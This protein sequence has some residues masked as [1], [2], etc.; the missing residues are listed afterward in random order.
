MSKYRIEKFY[1]FPISEDQLNRMS[2]MGWEL[3]TCVTIKEHAL[4]NN[5]I[6]YYF[7]RE[8]INQAP[9]GEKK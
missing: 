2:D 9:T 7:K 5:T 6:V 1:P 3:V 8:L 4:I